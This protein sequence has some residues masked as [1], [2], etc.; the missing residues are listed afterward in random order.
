LLLKRSK[1]FVAS[2]IL[3][4]SGS[5]AITTRAEAA[6]ASTTHSIPGGKLIRITT[7]G[8]RGICFQQNYAC[9]G[10]GY[11]GLGNQTGNDDWYRQFWIAGSTDF[12]DRTRRHN[13]TTYAGFRQWRNGVAK[14]FKFSGNASAWATNAANLGIRVDQTPKVGAGR[15]G[16]ATMSP[17]SMTLGSITGSSS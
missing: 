8:V 4:T 3:L 14:P 16:T 12:N 13:C 2:L 9:T 7:Q 6:V 17:T 15:S 1:V 10:G 11:N 5:L